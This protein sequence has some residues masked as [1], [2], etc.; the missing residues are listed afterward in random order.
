MSFASPEE[1]NV[2]VSRN[3]GLKLGGLAV[4]AI[5]NN[6]NKQTH[7]LRRQQRKAETSSDTETEHKSK[8]QDGKQKNKKKLLKSRS[9][10]VSFDKVNKKL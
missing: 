8:A 1:S 4:M 10:L 2:K 3:N 7:K 5:N 6:T 9:K